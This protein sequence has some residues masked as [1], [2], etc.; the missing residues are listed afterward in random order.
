MAQATATEFLEKTVKA[1]DINSNPNYSKINL[2]IAKCNIRIHLATQALFDY[3]SPAFEWHPEI[4]IEVARPD[5]EIF[6]IENNADVELPWKKEDF[7]EGSRIRGL[8]QGDLLATYDL[9]Y[10]NLSMFDTKT[11]K[12]LFVVDSADLMPEWE[13]GAPLRNVLTWALASRGIYLVHTAAVGIAGKGILISGPGGSGKSTT[14]ALAT[15]NGF[16]TT[17]DDYCAVSLNGVPKAH[18]VYGLLKLVPERF[19]TSTALEKTNSQVR[20][21]GKVHFKLGLTMVSEINL[22]AIVFPQVTESTNKPTLLSQRDSFLRL[23]ASSMSQL[24]TPDAGLFRTLTQLANTIPAYKWEIGPDTN[25]L[26]N[27]LRKL[28][29]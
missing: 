23:M 20:S 28:C 22:G 24:A 5:I 7:L 14:T 13:F 2:K 17:G 12:G 11:N 27:N 8:V 10:S 18:A 19:G 6:V 9:K 16:E 29:Q 15:Q 21:D 4:E 26:M 1:L 3:V 25:E